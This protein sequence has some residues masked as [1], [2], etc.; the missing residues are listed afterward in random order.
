MDEGF[1]F[2]GSNC[3]IEREDKLTQSVPAVVLR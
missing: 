3:V 1:A 2:P